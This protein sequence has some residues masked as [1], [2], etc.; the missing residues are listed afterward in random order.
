[1]SDSFLIKDDNATFLQFT[2]FKLFKFFKL[3]PP[4]GVKDILVNFDSKLNLT[5]P[6]KSILFFNGILFS[7]IH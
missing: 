2:F 7:Q 6:K 1:M 3:I 4:K 5:K